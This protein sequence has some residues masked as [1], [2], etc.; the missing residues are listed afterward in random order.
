LRE[1][2]LKQR[3]PLPNSKRKKKRLRQLKQRGLDKRKKQL[4]LLRPRGLD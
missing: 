4:P 3:R 2:R 1:K